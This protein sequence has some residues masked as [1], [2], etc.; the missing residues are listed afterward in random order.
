MKMA[1]HGLFKGTEK[2]MNFKPKI[3]WCQSSLVFNG[4]Q[5]IMT[6]EYPVNMKKNQLT[7]KIFLEFS[8]PLHGIFMAHES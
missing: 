4:L 2:P 6:H 7:M 3:S 5:Q 8:W 1:F